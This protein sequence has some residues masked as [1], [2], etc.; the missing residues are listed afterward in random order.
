MRGR[1]TKYGRV[2][3][4][5][6]REHAMAAILNG[7]TLHGNTRAYGGTFLI[8]SDYMR[9]SV[10]LAALMQV[11]SIFVWTHD[12][13]ALGED[14]PT[15]QPIEQ[16]ASLRAIP[17][18]STVVRP[19]G[20]Q[21]SVAWAWKTILERRG[22]ADR[23]RA[24]AAEHPGLRAWRRRRPV[25]E[26]FASAQATSPWAPMCWR[27]RRA[28]RPDVIFIATG[29]E[30]QVAI[31][32]REELLQGR[33][34]NRRSSRLGCRAWSGSR[35]RD[36]EYRESVLPA[37]DPGACVHRGGNR[38]DLETAMSVTPAAPSPSSTLVH[39]PTTRPCSVNSGS[40]TE[41]AVTAAQATRSARSER[42]TV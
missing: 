26:T 28:A 2:L 29:S 19:G 1:G 24:Y 12:S 20:C 23:P 6:I 10:R 9:P 22:R 37:S 41:H 16:L 42:S 25:G 3:H 32:A 39:P 18:S 30:V 27:R 36:A 38:P 5:G 35:S 14:G 34:V 7:I 33:K 13:V 21:R 40:P 31:E 4:F 17:G 15:H 8:F 11:P